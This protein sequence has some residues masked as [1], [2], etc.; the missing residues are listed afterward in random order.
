[1]KNVALL[2]LLLISMRVSAQGVF[3]NNTNSAIEKAVAGIVSKRGYPKKEDSRW[4]ADVLEVSSFE[5]AASKYKELYN[6]IGN[7]IV[8]IDGQKP[9]ILSG[10]YE[11]PSDSKRNQSIIFSMLPS[12]GLMQNVKVELQLIQQA[13]AWKVALAVYE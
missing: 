7:S 10:Q 11:A 2:V 5:A 1:M 13:N 8:R 12:T 4:R 9:Y 6:Q 3:A